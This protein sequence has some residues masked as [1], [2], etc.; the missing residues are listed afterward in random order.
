MKKQ[1]L[2]L[3]AALAAVFS[4][5][6]AFAEA[7]VTGK[8][9]HESAKFTTTGTT[10]GAATAHGKDAFKTETSARIYIDGEIDEV[11]E[12]STYHVELN[13]MRDSKGV[14]KYDGNESYTQ[15]DALREAYVDTTVEDWSIRAGKQQVVWG[16]ADGMKLLD[17]INPTDYSEMA[18]NQM[19][20]SRIPVW[21]VNAE[22]DAADGGSYQVILSEAKSS[23][24]AGL[25]NASAKGRTHSNGDMGH[26]F[27]MKG[28]D[29]ITGKTNGFLNIAP[30]IGATAQVFNGGFGDL[31]GF[32]KSTVGEFITNVEIG[33]FQGGNGDGL[34]GLT[35]N[36]GANCSGL[37]DNSTADAT[38]AA[39]LAGFASNAATTTNVIDA[40]TIDSTK[41]AT[42][43][44][45]INPGSAFA[46]MTD[47][48]FNTFNSF[49]GATSEY[50][51]VHD[52]ENKANTG[53]RYKNS[54]KSGVNYSL[55][56]LNH[57]DTNPYIELHWEDSNGNALTQT[58]TRV[59][60]DSTTDAPGAGQA[61]IDGKVYN[62]ISLGNDSNGT[63][64]GYVS[65]VS[66]G[67]ALVLNPA[68]LVFEEKLNKIHSIGG[69]FDTAIETKG[70]GPVVLRGEVLYNKDEMMPVVDRNKLGYGDLVGGLKMT[71]SDT[72]KYVLG[73]DI[74]ALTNMMISGQFIQIRNLDYVDNKTNS[75]GV[76]CGSKVNCGVYTSDMATMHLT[77]GLNKAEENKEFYSLFFSKPFGAS[78]EH[79]W[80]NIFMFEEN[81]GKWNRLDAEFSIDDDTQATVE[82]NKY[83]GDENTQFGQLEKSSNI[84][85]G[86]KYSF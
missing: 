31:S 20:D 18:Q 16:T 8:I 41:T 49:S 40:T 27:I 1:N 86:V 6:T 34:T 33:A 70:L 79:R 2:I 24:F 76:A 42:N 44:A 48:T 35:L 73:A 4:A 53:L 72:F 37:S 15:R 38:S 83:W 28:V 52:G 51:V 47:A 50:R 74:T 7:E 3:S 82:Y 65:G 36:Q 19:E 64:V 12:G 17:M 25:G 71:K 13:L 78:G 75:D 26:A 66:D 23:N 62:S 14:G 46:Y 10:I 21:M 60:G 54:T 32:N 59:V 77:N 29:T 5:S 45:G 68:T 63:L 58:V 11:N 81:G 57:Y 67:N 43:E 61:D 84:Q 30:D 56:Y 39:C 55:N 69:S 80:N 22:T 85:V 9:V